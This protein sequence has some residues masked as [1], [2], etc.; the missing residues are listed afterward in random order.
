MTGFVTPFVFESD[1]TL[2]EFTT[3]ASESASAAA[4][5]F[6]TA[7]EF[8]FPRSSSATEPTPLFVGVAIDADGE[9]LLD[10]NGEVFGR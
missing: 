2:L 1:A 4:T 8:P 5:V 9:P 10:P 7:K 3:L 6:D